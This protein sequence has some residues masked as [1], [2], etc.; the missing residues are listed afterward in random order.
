MSLREVDIATSLCSGGTC[1]P[2]SNYAYWVRVMG[3]SFLEQNCVESGNN[4]GACVD[5]IKE[6]YGDTVP[7]AEPWCAEFAFA[8]HRL[9]C[10][11]LGA[12]EVLPHKKGA[13]DMLRASSNVPIRI[14]SYPEAGCVGYRYSAAGSTGHIFTV[15]AVDSQTG[16]AWTI[17]GNVNNRVALRYYD[18]DY[19]TDDSKGVRFIHVEDFYRTYWADKLRLVFY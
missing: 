6:I 15:I 7:L 12:A 9:A 4:R 17:E 11:N 3:L 13:L 10:R 19:Y 14:D 16:R 2:E 5:R 1:L 18:Y 8:L